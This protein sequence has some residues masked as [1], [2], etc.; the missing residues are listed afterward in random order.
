MSP[1]ELQDSNS[2]PLVV[3]K[4]APRTYD[5]RDRDRETDS[6]VPS[7]S[8]TGGGDTLAGSVSQTSSSAFNMNSPP[9]VRR[10]KSRGDK[11]KTKM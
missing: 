5:R 1:D 9:Y 11:P 3:E 4:S 6:H 7:Y 2:L 8:P 10:D